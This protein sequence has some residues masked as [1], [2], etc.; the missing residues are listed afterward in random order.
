MG[1][2]CKRSK[3][4]P[5]TA[6]KEQNKAQEANP[7]FKLVNLNKGGKLIDAYKTGGT[8]AVEK[9]AKTELAQYL[10]ND[11]NGHNVSVAD[12]VRWQ[13][14]CSSG[15]S[16]I[17]E[18]KS[19][20]ELEKEYKKDDFNIVTE[21]EA[22]WDLSKRGPMGETAFHFLYLLDSPLHSEVA[23]ILLKFYPKL[24]LDIYEGEEYFGESALHIAI[25]FG[26]FESVKL[27]VQN[28]ANV[29]QRATGRFFLPEDQKKG[30]TPST[31]Y[32]GFAYYGEYPLAFAACT[33]NQDIY[34]Y[35]IE[36]NAN[37]DLQDSFG[38]TVLHMVVI[39][40]QADMYKYIVN[41]HQKPAKTHI[42]NNANLT[43]LTLA[44]K[45]GRHKIFKEML[46]LG[47][48]KRF[49]LR[50]I[51]AFLH[52]SFIST[53]VYCRP[54]S[55]LLAVNA[56]TDIVRFIC[57]ILV[58]IGCVGNIALEVVE[59]G[60]QGL[61]GFLKNCRHAPAQTIFIISCIF[62]LACIPFRFLQLQHVEDILLIIAVP[63]SWLF[64]LFF[65]RFFVT[66]N[67]CHSINCLQKCETNWSF[68]SYDIQNI[69]YDLELFTSYFWL[70]LH[71]YQ[72]FERTKYSILAKAVFAV[73]MILV[74][75]LL[76]NMLIAMMGNTYQQ[77]ISKSEK[78]WRKQWA[79]IVVV[80]ERGFSKKQLLQYQK[81]YSV[82]FSGPPEDDMGELADK[83]EK[84]MRALVVI[85][86]GSK[87]KAK[88]RKGAINNWKRVGKE[89]IKQ[90]KQ[91][92][93]QG[94]TG[95]VTLSKAHKKHKSRKHST[96]SQSTD[97][98]DTDGHFANVMQQLAW[99]KD[100]DL[101]KGQ[102][103]IS[104]PDII[105]KASPRSPMKEVAPP[106]PSPIPNGKPRSFTKHVKV[107]CRHQDLPQ[108]L[109]CDEKR[110]FDIALPKV[111]EEPK[112]S[113]EVPKVVVKSPKSD[114]GSSQKSADRYSSKLSKSKSDDG[115]D[116]QS[117]VDIKQQAFASK[118]KNSGTT[119]RRKYKPA[120][121][122][123]SRSSSTISLLHLSETD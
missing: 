34:D 96:A 20:E 21:H 10:Y 105:E 100:I 19:D 16:T 18:T 64:L 63:G 72:A 28:G 89:V 71:K 69:Y 26:D 3:S 76:L 5:D 4:D 86:S 62:I 57:E 14:Q 13:R 74:P 39:S 30:K 83:D 48:I 56:T 27:L 53:A 23:R 123:S 43:P 90:M 98:D 2:I 119:K 12:Y 44:S 94:K 22:C 82:K 101:T 77:V 42:K 91:Q 41:H 58:C 46:E 87:T 116:S 36:H 25:V 49:F 81:E 33:G 103:F 118:E 51:L 17:L 92:R 121:D 117:S 9:I 47:S 110:L 59:I 61:L 79:K 15:D 24:A 111:P 35:L 70:R 109:E 106:E 104:D 75:I 84:E 95:P 29:N 107:P 11:G 122:Q 66:T 108:A 99:E 115:S 55:D 32:E 78:E 97:D 93:K 37:P 67:H 6:W 88:Q 38:N 54:A 31:N 65:A 60:S 45:L 113:W 52:L 102:A 114:D 1:N 8:A 120:K 73:F 7:I 85:K 50:L 68:C 112:K 40:D 80:L